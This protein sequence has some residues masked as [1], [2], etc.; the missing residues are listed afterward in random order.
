MEIVTEMDTIGHGLDAMPEDDS[1][2]EDK[3]DD[4]EDDEDDLYAQ[5]FVNVCLGCELCNID[6]L[7]VK[8]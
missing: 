8:L 6:T 3:L 5:L 1:V 4:V 2:A 7:V